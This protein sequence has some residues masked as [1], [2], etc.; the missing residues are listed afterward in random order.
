MLEEWGGATS[1]PS[2]TLLL[3]PHLWDNRHELRSGPDICL[4]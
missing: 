2:Q 1:W 4:I 3:P